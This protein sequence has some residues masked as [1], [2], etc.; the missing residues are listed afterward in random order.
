[1][2]T[3]RFILESLKVRASEWRRAES[4]SISVE[5]VLM[6]PILLWGYIGMYVFFEGLRENNINLK[7]AYTIGDLLSRETDEINQT[8]LNGMRDVFTW[9]TRT[10]EDVAVRVTVIRYDEDADEHLLVWSRASGNN[11]SAYQ[12]QL[13]QNGVNGVISDHVPIMADADTAI[14]VETWVQFE[15]VLNIG[16]TETEIYNVVVTAPRFSEQLLWEG[17]N[18]GSGTT[19]DDGTGGTDGSG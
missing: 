7:A 6:F 9:L 1:M 14:V 12:A 15:P 13:G 11:L 19:H 17:L 16:L 2:F 8:Y 10:Q 18:A 4:G 3:V 5:A